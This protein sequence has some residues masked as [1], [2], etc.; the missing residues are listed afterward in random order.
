LPY[1]F[2]FVF[3]VFNCPFASYCTSCCGYFH[4]E[5]FDGFGRERT[6]DLGFQRPARKPVDHRS[7][8][9]DP[10]TVQPVASRYTD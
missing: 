1:L 2:V 10:R 4:F 3:V 8:Y 6:R 7:R 5:K 9:F